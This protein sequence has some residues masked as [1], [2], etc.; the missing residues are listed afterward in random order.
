MVTMSPVVV[1]RFTSFIIPVVKVNISGVIWRC[2]DVNKSQVGNSVQLWSIAFNPRVQRLRG[3]TSVRTI[4]DLRLDY[5]TE[6][7]DIT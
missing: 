5:Q 3:L 4:K 2:E 7:F 1:P 6:V